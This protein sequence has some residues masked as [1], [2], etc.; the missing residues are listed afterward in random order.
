MG[1][2]G[3]LYRLP[4]YLRERNVS[5]CLHLVE[6]QVHVMQVVLQASVRIAN[7]SPGDRHPT[8]PTPDYWRSLDHSTVSP[9]DNVLTLIV[10]NGDCLGTI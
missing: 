9:A 3:Y 10:K 4:V 7:T 1:F 8:R 5:P 6:K 2:A